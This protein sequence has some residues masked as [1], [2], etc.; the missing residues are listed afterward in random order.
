MRYSDI[1][2]HLKPYGIVAH[3]KTTINHAFAAAV[4]PCD[5]F[6][7]LRIRKAVTFLGQDPDSDLY[8]VYC[9][10][11][12]ETWDH[13][14]AMVQRSTF[15]GHGHRLGNLLPCCKPCNSKKGNK[16]WQQ[17]LETL[18]VPSEARAKRIATI[19]HYLDN[20]LVTEAVPE[21]LAEYHELQGIKEKIIALMAQADVIAQRL[22]EHEQRSNPAV[23]GC[24]TRKQR[25]VPYLEQ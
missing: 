8:C 24:C 18:L 20:F 21:H 14:F 12:A 9:G 4:A 2:R 13:V 23:K 16:N 10:A 22:R 1:T 7:E 11:L 6:D 19:Q 17:F 15:S 5:K 3:R 25:T